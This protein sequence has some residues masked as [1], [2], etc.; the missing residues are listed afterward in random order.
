MLALRRRAALIGVYVFYAVLLN[1]VGTVILQSILSF[2]VSKPQGS[3]LEACKDLSIAA[4]SF[5]TA[6][7]LSRI[8]YRPAVVFALAMVSLA[9]FA[10]PLV[11][12]FATAEV[13]FL[14]IG[15]S[16]ALVK[17]SVYSLIGVLEQDPRG[18]AG[19]TSL[20]EGCF[21]VG[22]LS[23]VWIFS[24][25]IDNQ[26]PASLAW[27]NVY[28]GLGG[29]GLVLAGLWL[30]TP[31]SERSVGEAVRHGALIDD[32]RRIPALFISPFLVAFLTSIFLYVLIEQSLGTWLPTYNREILGLPVSM[33]VQAGGFLAGGLAIGRLAGAV[34]LRRLSWAPVL[35]ACVAGAAG[36][37]LLA[38]A[39]QPAH[40]FAVSGWRSAPFQAFVLP[41]A[42]LFLA[43][44]YPALNSAILSALPER[45]QAPMTGLIIAFSAL[46]GT[47]GSFLTGQFFAHFGGRNAFG[48][49]LT[50]LLLLAGALI[51]LRRKMPAAAG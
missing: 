19:L 21:M 28:W 9:C 17:V 26:N 46:G 12:G 48:L 49:A 8:G 22:V 41:L 30:L 13:L 43:P 4:V 39:L 32:L 40:P 29:A 38:L 18:H 44:I 36:V 51:W 50:A 6:S 23:G 37:I 3:I 25:F 24:L 5:A 11:P 33:S 31:M 16:F 15:V 34:I 2:G 35:L 14:A 27:L 47:F 20:I 42:G 1:S 10:M 45:S 7:F